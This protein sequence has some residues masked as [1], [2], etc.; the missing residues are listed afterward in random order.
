MAFFCLNSVLLWFSSH[1]LFTHVHSSNT[2]ECT[3]HESLNLPSEKK[4]CIILK[5]NLLCQHDS[6]YLIC[7]ICAEFALEICFHWLFLWF[8]YVSNRKW[9]RLNISP[10]NDSFFCLDM[11]NILYK[12]LHRYVLFCTSTVQ[13]QGR[14]LCWWDL[15]DIKKHELSQ[16]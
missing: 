1:L 5:Y 10:A 13:L 9:D 12:C 15:G 16:S 6:L 14:G 7:Y 3:L 4:T 8:C 2:E 11:L